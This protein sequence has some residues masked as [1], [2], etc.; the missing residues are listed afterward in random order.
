MTPGDLLSYGW[1]VA[2]KHGPPIHLIHFVTARC[3]LRCAHCF[4]WQALDADHRHELTLEEIDQTA[5]SLPRLLLLSLTGG[6]PFVR[7]DLG[8]ICAS[9]IRHCRPHILTISTNGAYPERME[10]IIPPLL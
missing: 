10:S 5:R 7:K 3:N 6:E 2:R 1:R 8:E 9:Y 4:Y